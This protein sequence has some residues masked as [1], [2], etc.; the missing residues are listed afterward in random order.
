MA[1]KLSERQVCCKRNVEY[2]LGYERALSKATEHTY[3]NK[4]NEYIHTSARST[5]STRLK[6]KLVQ[7]LRSC[8][9]RTRKNLFDVLWLKVG[10]QLKVLI[11]HEKAAF[12]IT[13]KQQKE[14]KTFK[15]GKPE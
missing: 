6:R 11:Y 2:L 4:G 9:T 10:I 5:R 12:N 8:G 7:S 3:I 1:P 15:S 14:E 13:E